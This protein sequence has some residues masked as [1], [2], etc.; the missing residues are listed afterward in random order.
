MSE[1]VRND[2]T[3][4]RYELVE[5]GEVRGVA[6]YER[7]ADEIRFTH[8]EVSPEHRTKGRGARLVQAALDDVRGSTDLRVVPLCPFVADFVD[9]HPDYQELLRR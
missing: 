2:T 8:T 3:R 5:D 9:D 7:T 4:Q 6:E 1:E